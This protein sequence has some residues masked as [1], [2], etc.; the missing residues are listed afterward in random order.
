[1]PSEPNVNQTVRV[2]PKGVAAVPRADQAPQDLSRTLVDRSELP[3]V[4]ARTVSAAGA[5]AVHHE[6]AAPPRERFRVTMNEKG[7]RVA[8]PGGFMTPPLHTMPEVGGTWH[9]GAEEVLR[10]TI[11][12]E[13]GPLPSKPGEQ[14]S[15]EVS[16]FRTP[17]PEGSYALTSKAMLDERRY[18]GDD[19][20][21]K[22]VSDDPRWVVVPAGTTFDVSKEQLRAW[23]EPVDEHISRQVLSIET[24]KL[25]Q[26]TPSNPNCGVVVT[27]YN[28]NGIDVQ[29]GVMPTELSNG[30]QVRSMSVSS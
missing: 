17:E 6:T 30:V 20:R 15:P 22:L 1:M 14:R 28:M 25:T 11:D 8:V 12:P 18:G 19:M 4:V 21:N 13:R 5:A 7:D 9:I 2:Y 10:V 29:T 3:S 24:G 23:G 16:L 26:P 27:N